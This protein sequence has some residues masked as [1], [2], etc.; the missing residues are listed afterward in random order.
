MDYI[1]AIDLLNMIDDSHQIWRLEDGKYYSG[2]TSRNLNE[3][4]IIAQI[5]F[6]LIEDG[7]AITDGLNTN[8]VKIC[9]LDSIRVIKK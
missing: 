8:G 3:L 9:K 2:K 1:I 7:W 4:Q 6:V 5:P